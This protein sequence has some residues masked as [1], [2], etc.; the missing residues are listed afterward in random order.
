M[1]VGMVSG[2]SLSKAEEKNKNQANRMNGCGH[3]DQNKNSI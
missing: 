3:I 2:L 1:K